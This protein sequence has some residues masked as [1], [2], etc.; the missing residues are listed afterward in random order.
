M[1]WEVIGWIGS[2]VIVYSMMQVRI[3]RLRLINLV[4]SLISLAYATAI[5]AWPLAGLNGVLAAIQIYHLVKIFRA[6]HDAAS[7]EVIVVRPQGELVRHL[8]ERHGDELRALHPRFRE[9][10]DSTLAFVTLSEE[11]IVGL[12]LATIEGDVAHLDVDYVTP[13]YRGLTPGE[14][15]FRRSSVWREAGVRL[16]RVSDDGPDYYTSIGF[17]RGPDGFSLVLEG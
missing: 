13:T 2:A 9:P 3:L 14:F 10:T 8:L 7:F 12:L 4:G 5:Q 15:V 17:T 1:V 16:V 11:T 6:R